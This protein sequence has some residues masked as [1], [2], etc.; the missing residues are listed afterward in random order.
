MRTRIFRR[1]DLV[2]LWVGLCLAATAN[3]TQAAPPDEEDSAGPDRASRHSFDFSIGTGE[4]DY[5]E[6]VTIDPV[7]S[8]WISDYLRLAAG[9][10]Y[11]DARRLKFRV[12]GA[13]WTARD[14]TETW[15]S[16]GATVQENR[17]GVD[18]LDLRGE[19]GYALVQR[20]GV[21]GT[22][23]LGLGLRRQDFTRDEFVLFS[24]DETAV[25]GAVGETYSI[26]Y[27]TGGLDGWFN[28]ADDLRGGVTLTGGWV[29]SNEAD[30]DLIGRVEGGGGYLIE[31]RVSLEIRLTR[32][33]AA[34]LGIFIEEQSLDGAR[35]TAADFEDGEGV[36]TVVEWP[37]NTTRMVGIEVRW[38][39]L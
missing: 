18:G 15:R 14:E 32:R 2:S 23:W 24:Q 34:V 28:I 7:D 13:Y 19:V 20:S 35:V 21:D 26:G 1:C 29:F 22:G 36:T 4:V 11:E 12:Q 6:T 38:I 31:A 3:L 8:E 37:D 10:I 16:G 25:S 39:Y 17:L 9:W 5:E 30:N 33:H 27:L